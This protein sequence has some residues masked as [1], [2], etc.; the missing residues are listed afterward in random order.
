MRDLGKPRTYYE[1]EFGIM[2]NNDI[3]RDN[4]LKGEIQV[5]SNP[6]RWPIELAMM[7][8]RIKEEATLLG[9]GHIVFYKNLACTR[10]EED[11]VLLFMAFA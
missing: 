11:A 1:V 7:R 2:F 6:T 5:P 8:K 9:I 4:M 3:F 10:F